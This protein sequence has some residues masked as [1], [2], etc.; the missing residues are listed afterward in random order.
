MNFRYEV[1]TRVIM[2][3][4]V[5]RK[6]AGE[7]SALG[8]RALIVTGGSS[9]RL[10]GAL[11]D[12]RAALREKN[13]EWEVFDRIEN[14]PTP[15]NVEEAG[16][17]ARKLKADLIIAIGGG[18]PLDAGKAAAVLA[19][20]EMDPLE[21]FKGPLTVKPLPVV[22]IPTTAG[23]GSEVTPYSIL[24]RRDLQTKK[25]FGHPSLFPRVALLDPEY[26]YSLPYQVTVNTAIDA[27]SHAMEGYLGK[28]SMP[29]SDILAEQAMKEFGQCIEDLVNNNLTPETR[30]RLLYMSMLAG[31][32]IA[33]TGT[34]I[35]HGMGYSLTYFKNIPHG[36]ANGLVMKEYLRFNL[37]C[38]E[39]KINRVIRLL[40]LPGME[41]FGEIL[42]KLLPC[43]E[44]FTDAELHQYASL[45]MLQRSTG[46][47]IRE[48]REEDI[49]H[50]LRRSL[51]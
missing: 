13:L 27:L 7:F 51:K 30:E 5:V 35:M 17:A 41:K 16:A 11:D 36:R 3:P 29:L 49:F 12:V 18:S 34:T 8:K 47:N 19:V 25:S 2:G 38:A 42:D 39:E 20:K 40:G 15:E 22:A 21:L 31:M 9:G 48:A 10:S 45:V 50:I 46:S 24:T 4:G 23:T 32:V 6:N 43:E 44:Q 1:P 37:E 28:R 14:N 26:T 33:H